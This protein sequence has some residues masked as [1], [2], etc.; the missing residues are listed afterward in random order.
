MPNPNPTLPPPPLTLS[1]SLITYDRGPHPLTNAPRPHHWAYYLDTTTTTTTHRR[2]GGG[3]AAGADSEEERGTIFQLRGM[4]GGFYYPGPE[5]AGMGQGGEVGGVVGKL[6]VGEVRVGEAR[7]GEVG[8]GEVGVGGRGGVGVDGEGGAEADAVLGVVRMIDG[9]LR[10]VGVVVDEGAAWN[11]Q[12]W[13]LEGLER[14]KK[15]GVVR[16][17]LERGRVKAWLAERW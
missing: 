5:D 15:V 3:T 11:C 7:V 12:D 1:L 10:E 9:V 17:D 6:E 14:L 8:V 16:E 4:P 2:P 13:A